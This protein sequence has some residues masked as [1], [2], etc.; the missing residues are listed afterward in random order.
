MNRKLNDAIVIARDRINDLSSLMTDILVAN[1]I[2]SNYLPGAVEIDKLRG[3]M[4]S[5]TEAIIH[6]DNNMY[7]SVTD[8]ESVELIEG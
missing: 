7:I 3:L 5:L 1:K 8:V 6:V 2:R 4:D